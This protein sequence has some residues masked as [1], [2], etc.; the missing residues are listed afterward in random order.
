MFDGTPKNVL[1]IDDTF[2]TGATCQSAASAL[3]LGGA[4]V[5]AGVVTGRVIDT[6]N[7][8]Y[9]DKLELW[10]Q[11]RRLRFSFAPAASNRGRHQASRTCH[12][13]PIAY[14]ACR[15]RCRPQPKKTAIT[16]DV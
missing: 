3:A 2:T 4:R 11:Q 13:R 6:G 5:V 8:N 10:E 14:T 9:P 16:R 15:P 1:L 7:P 12:T